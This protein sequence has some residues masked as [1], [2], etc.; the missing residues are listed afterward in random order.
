[1]VTRK[2]LSL[3]VLV[4][5]LISAT[6]LMALPYDSLRAYGDH[7]HFFNIAALPG[8][9]YIDFWS[10]FPP[11]FPFLSELLYHLSGG[12]EHV[13]TYLLMLLLIAAN[14]GCVLL[15]ERIAARLDPQDYQWRA[16]V[17]AALSAAL[18]Y[19]WR[20]FDT[21]PV[22]F[23]LL[24]LHLV[25]S[26]RD[27]IPAGLAFGLGILT[28][29][30]PALF[31]PALWKFLPRRRAI[32]ITALALV[33]PVLVY[34][35]LWLASPQFTKAS[36]QSQAAKGSWETAWALL[37]GNFRSGNFGPLDDRIDPAAAAMPMG[38]PPLI[39]P[40]LRLAIFGALGLFLFLRARLDHPTRVLSFI[41]LTA[42]I[43]FLWSPGWSV[44]W[45][46]Y[47][48]PLIFLT[49]PP[50]L[51]LLLGAAHLFTNLLEWPILLSRDMFYTLPLTVLLRTLLLFLLALV[52]WQQCAPP[53]KA[54]SP[55]NQQLSP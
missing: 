52:W 19:H 31:L 11:L 21:F 39:N 23:A 50:R 47:L 15:F 30:F 14:L 16:V 22:F 2:P 7:P 46:L 1:M 40:W 34:A 32:T 26:R 48:L 8:L 35:A 49:L 28:K 4:F 13:Y 37:D 45:V 10:E 43:F 5:L 17:F 12:V 9:P 29:L 53:P 36:L 33:L 24:A 51:A 44:Q 3:P 18:P 38:N 6:L 54:K 20:Y 41:G 27:S 42:A 55:E 25:L